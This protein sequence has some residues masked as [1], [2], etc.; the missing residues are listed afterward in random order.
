MEASYPRKIMPTSARSLATEVILRTQ[1]NSAIKHHNFLRFWR[2]LLVI[3][4]PAAKQIAPQKL[5]KRLAF[6]PFDILSKGDLNVRGHVRANARRVACLGLSVCHRLTS[7]L[8]I[9]TRYTIWYVFDFMPSLEK[10][11]SFLGYQLTLSFRSLFNALVL[12]HV[13]RP[14]QFF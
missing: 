5:E 7:G 13:G 1:V 9:L 12:R 10:R 2:H 6:L 8:W 11:F 3:L 4:M 14:S